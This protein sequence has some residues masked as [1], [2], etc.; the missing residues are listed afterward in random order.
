M[1]PSPVAIQNQRIERITAQTLVVG[2]DIAKDR[3]VG[4]VMTSRGVVLTPRGLVVA[5]SRVGFEQFWAALQLYCAQYQAA[6]VVVGLEP[7]GHY[8]WALA[9]WLVAR[10]VT[11]GLVDPAIT[12]RHKENRDHTPSKSDPK[13]AVVIA[14]MVNRGY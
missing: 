12:R 5:N 8:W 10:G 14:D 4:Q 7:T 9:D 11:V 13:D 1:K 2:V 6:D 3:H